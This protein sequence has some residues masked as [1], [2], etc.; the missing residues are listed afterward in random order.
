M[1]NNNMENTIIMQNNP[2]TTIDERLFILMKEQMNTEEQLQF[3]ESFKIYLNF[4]NDN[5]K[6]IINLDDI[7]KWVGFSNK[8]NAKTLLTKKFI[9]DKDYI[10]HFCN[11]KNGLIGSEKEIIMLNVSTFKKFCM[12]AST[13]RA[14]DICDYYLKMENIMF[15]YTQE[16]LNEYKNNL[17]ETQTALKKFIEYDEELF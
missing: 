12:K 14:D 1:S 3:I 8:G 13:K 16:K 7:W 15:Q 6:F 2:I 17:V 9:K 10:N 4:G 5:S 11:R